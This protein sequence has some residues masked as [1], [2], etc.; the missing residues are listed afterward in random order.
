MARLL[1]C[2]LQKIEVFI[3]AI[4]FRMLIFV[5]I[6]HHVASHHS[7]YSHCYGQSHEHRNAIKISSKICLELKNTYSKSIKLMQIYFETRNVNFIFVHMLGSQNRCKF[8]MF[9]IKQ[10]Y[11]CNL[12]TGV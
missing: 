9:V 6:E 8:T 3:L 2:V 1:K 5:T 7:Y 4:A 11:S 10:V 12:R